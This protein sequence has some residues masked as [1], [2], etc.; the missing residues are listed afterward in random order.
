[1][2]ALASA[3]GRVY[4]GTLYRG[5]FVSTDNGQTWREANNGLG[6]LAVNA[7]AAAGANA[8]AATNGGLYRTSEGGQSWTLAV[9]VAMRSLALTAAG[10][11]AGST[12]G[13]VFRSTDNGATWTERTAL[14]NAPIVYALAMQGENLFAGTA[15]GLFRSADNGA[16]W[17]AVTAGLP[18]TGAPIV[19]ALITNDNKLYLGTGSVYRD[20]QNNFL[21]QVYV[22]ADNGQNWTG[23]GAAIRIPVNTTTFLP[24]VPALAADSGKLYALTSQG[25]MV[26]DGQTWSE[27]PNRGLPIGGQ[28]YAF[29]R[30][31]DVT[32][33]ATAGGIFMPASDGQSWTQSNRGLTAASLC[34]L[35]NSNNRLYCLLRFER[36]LSQQRCRANLDATDRRQQR[37]GTA[38]RNAS[39]GRARQQRIHFGL[40]RRHFSL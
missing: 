33:L 31:G 16:A 38:F 1:M 27:P 12:T 39:F 8:F 15:R 9:P 26:F 40:L 29:L 28:A 18:N 6:N 2:Q 22:S 13:R 19:T 24:A 17:T 25:A 21:P 11:F 37:R 32:L 23:V 30:S 36:P 20:A 10:L 3:D 5:V 7:L 35:R 4:A 34:D 14:A